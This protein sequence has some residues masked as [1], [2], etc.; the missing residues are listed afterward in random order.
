MA[1]LT[2]DMLPIG[3][4]LDF[5]TTLD[6]DLSTQHS[7]C[8][9]V[10]K[11]EC[12]WWT[13]R[14]PRDLDLAE[15]LDRSSIEK[16]IDVHV[17][18]VN[19]P[20][21]R[22]MDVSSPFNTSS[23]GV[24]PS[25]GVPIPSTVGPITSAPCRKCDLSSEILTKTLEEMVDLHS[26]CN[27]MVSSSE[28]Q[29]NLDMRR[30][31]IFHL[32][33]QAAWTKE[34]TGATSA[35]PR[36][37][38]PGSYK[39]TWGESLTKSDVLGLGRTGTKQNNRPHSGYDLSLKT[40]IQGGVYSSDPSSLNVMD[41]E[42]QNRS[43]SLPD[44]SFPDHPLNTN[45]NN[46][47]YDPLE[48]SKV[49]P[50]GRQNIQ[51]SL[52]DLTTSNVLQHTN[53][54]MEEYSPNLDV[55]A[56]VAQA[57]DNQFRDREFGD[58]AE[59]WVSESEEEGE[60][61]GEDGGADGSHSAEVKDKELDD[62]AEIWVSEEEGEDEVAE[63][64]V[65]DN[66]V[67][68]GVEDEGADG[69]LSAP[70]INRDLDDVAEIWVSEDEGEDEAGEG[71]VEDKTVGDVV[72]AERADGSHSAQVKNQELDDVAEIWVSDDEGEDEAA[73]GQ[74]ED[75]TVGEGV[76]DE[77]AE[78]SHSAQVKDKELDDVAEI[79]V[80]EEEGEDEVAEGSVINSAGVEQDWS[81][82]I[83]DGDAVEGRMGGVEKDWSSAT[84]DIVDDGAVE[85][86]T[87]PSFPISD[88]WPILEDLMKN[89][90]CST[91]SSD[92]EAIRPYRRFG[93]E[94]FSHLREEM[95]EDKVSDSGSDDI[96]V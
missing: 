73:E 26:Y 31:S 89:P 28:I 10:N 35:P 16:C 68:Y 74:V 82:G 57:V 92:T 81:S 19:D 22:A 24:S 79:W 9:I 93:P 45:R 8:R 7:L 52:A 37:D 42:T 61:D 60:Y 17:F 72:E 54:E 51:R 95:F 78:G 86:E 2:E 36:A 11:Y 1:V 53:L 13:G 56:A 88:S 71:Q 4:D 41:D 38:V 29:W 14:K 83:D 3:L 96:Y 5:L 25:A 40:G 58:V 43:I 76:E 84:E 49:C 15:V 44:Y 18:E 30:A 12:A 33:H 77:G 70:M 27:T 85:C 66:T 64:Q 94:D 59:N 47:L 91:F 21:V 65:E 80:S 63:G 62:V 87:R 34:T 90:Q 6:S 55:Q 20:E 46:L 39:W 75:K 32:F 48:K 50:L 23:M 67:G 69:S